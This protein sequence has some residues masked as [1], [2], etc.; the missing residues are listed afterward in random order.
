MS[1]EPSPSKADL[2]D[3]RRLP[4]VGPSI[5]MDLWRLGFRRAEEL[6][7][8]DPEALYQ[9]F[10]ALEGRHVD[11]CLLYVFRAA[12]HAVDCDHPEPKRLKWWD[13]KDASDD[14]RR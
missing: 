8:Q 2:Q 12:V 11:R 9:R 7:G 10:M 6:R 3:L 14:Q 5:A 13:F 4:G 1:T